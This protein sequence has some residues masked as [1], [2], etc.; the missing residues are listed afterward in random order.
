MQET[1]SIDLVSHGAFS[2]LF[3]GNNLA[4]GCTEVG[5]IV[6]GKAEA[7]CRLIYESYIPYSEHIEGNKSIG[8]APLTQDGMCRFGAL[9]IDNYDYDLMDIVRAIYEYNLP[10]IPCWSKSKKLHIYVFFDVEI[11]ADE[12]ISLLEAYREL[13]ACGKRT[14]IFPKQSKI[15]ASTK[16]PSWINIPY[17]DAANPD[18]HRK[19]VKADGTLASLDTFIKKAQSNIQSCPGPK[20]H[21]DKLKSIWFM[22]AP[23]CVQT[24]IMLHD[25]PKG[26]RNNWMFNVGV[27]VRLRDKDD[28]YAEV[29]REVNEAMHNPINELELENTIIKG[30]DKN[31]Y[32]YICNDMYRCDKNVC[33]KRAC[34]IS[35]KE[36]SGLS[37]G[38]MRQ[39]MTRPPTYEWDVNGVTISF[40]SEQEIMGQTKF[41]AMCMRFLHVMPRRIK[42]DTW[43]SIITRAMENIVV[44]E[45]EETTDNYYN[46]GAMF[47]SLL[48]MYFNQSVASEDISSVQSGNVVNMG[49]GYIYF[50]PAWFTSFFFDRKV[51][52]LSPFDIYRYLTIYGC[53][54]VSKNVM[55]Y[56]IQEDDRLPVTVEAVARNRAEQEDKVYVQ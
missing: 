18:N 43:S 14:E 3:S 38:E 29:V 19:M 1:F 9:D 32:F 37:Y 8:I 11:A 34:G 24:G 48:K 53:T 54:H 49:D 10:I 12:M 6:D 15:T 17:F 27:F 42:D 51:M 26:Y 46:E 36:S 28:D 33:K 23:P 35:C 13:F 47:E 39:I 30:L 4:Y 45:P 41:R 40:D 7:K 52:K 2:R 44:V 50:D 22:D 55:K 5:E 56:K 16:F 25:V 20:A 21:Y 31:T